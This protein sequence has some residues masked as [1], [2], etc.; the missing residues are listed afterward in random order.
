MNHFLKTSPLIVIR[1]LFLYFFGMFLLSLGIALSIKAG[2][3]VSPTTS[4]PYVLS[5]VMSFDIGLAT[6]LVFTIYIVVQAIILRDEFHHINW[7]QLFVASVFGGFLSFSN[8][9]VNFI[10]PELYAIRMALFL[11]SML[12]M[13]LGIIVYMSPNFLLQP[14]EGLVSALAQKSGWE[15]GKIKLYFDNFSI[16]TTII[17]ILF[18]G[19]GFIGIREGTFISALV[20]GKVISVLSKRITPILSAYCSAAN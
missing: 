10:S 11:F 12:L 7:L 20:F 16:A 3:G 14:P 13:A 17:L 19:V 8:N 9:L 6:T 1:K 5:Q 15:F 18:S 2:L 4:F